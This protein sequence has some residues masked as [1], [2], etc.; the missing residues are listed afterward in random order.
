[1]DK[2][3]QVFAPTSE[4]T[5]TNTSSHAAAAELQ[6][7]STKAGI[8]TALDTEIPC[9]AAQHL[10]Q[11]SLALHSRQAKL[12]RPS[13]APCCPAPVT[14]SAPDA[15]GVCLDAVQQL[16]QPVGRGRFGRDQRR[17]QLLNRKRALA[18]C[19][20]WVSYQQP[21]ALDLPVEGL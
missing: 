12:V 5:S 9:A 16:G 20:I 15:A 18:R 6:A 14:A 21:A 1:M 11:T 7:T 10:A 4:C 17:A 3:N 13:A 2:R 8:R 19:E